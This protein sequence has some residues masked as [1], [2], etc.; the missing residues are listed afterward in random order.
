MLTYVACDNHGD[1]DPIAR[2]DLED[3]TQI[4]EEDDGK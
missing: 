2:L 1:N 4:A 3:L